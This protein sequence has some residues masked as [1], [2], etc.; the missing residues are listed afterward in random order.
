MLLE[1][2]PNGPGSIDVPEVFSYRVKGWETDL[3]LHPIG[4]WNIIAN[5]T[6][7]NP[8]LTDYPQTPDLVGNRVPS[9]PKRIANVWTS[10]DIALPD[11]SEE[12]RVGKECVS[13]SRSRWSP[14][15]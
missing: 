12:R 14:Y 4:P 15:H 7:Q 11:R 13:T 3:N 2:D 5:F 6:L 10:Y 8:K 1:P 9:V